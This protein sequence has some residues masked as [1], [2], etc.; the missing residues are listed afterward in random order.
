MSLRVTPAK[1]VGISETVTD[2]WG[3]VDAVNADQPAKK[4]GP[5]MKEGR[6]NERTPRGPYGCRGA[7]SVRNRMLRSDESRLT[8]MS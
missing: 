3:I 2:W 8:R 4:R 7:L 6:L 1:A 5:S